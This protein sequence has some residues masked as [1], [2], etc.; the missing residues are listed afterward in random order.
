MPAS[1]IFRIVKLSHWLNG[2]REMICCNF[3]IVIASAMV[4]SGGSLV[5]IPRTGD[6]AQ[7]LL[8]D[9]IGAGEGHVVKKKY[10]ARMAESR[11]VGE[12]VGLDVVLAGALPGAQHDE[13]VW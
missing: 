3:S 2:P 5:G 9:F 11:T 1:S 13:S 12:R 10:A 6:A 4:C 8:V 7:K